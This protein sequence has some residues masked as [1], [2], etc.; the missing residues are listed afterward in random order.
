MRR[1][2]HVLVRIGRHRIAIWGRH[3]VVGG[4]VVVLDG[5]LSG[6]LRG[7]LVLLLVWNFRFP[8]SDQMDISSGRSFEVKVEPAIIATR[9][10]QGASI[11]LSAAH[12]DSAD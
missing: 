4:R 8:L 1:W 12:N 7:L 10:A 5:R 3:S 6:W 11:D 2:L 9:L